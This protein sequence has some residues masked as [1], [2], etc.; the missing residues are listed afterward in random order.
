MS[1]RIRIAISGGGVAGAV[2]MHALLKHPHLNPHIFESAPQFKEAGIAFGVTRQAQAALALIG[3]SATEYLER[4]GGV[5]MKGVHAYVGQGPDAGELVYEQDNIAIGKKTTTIVQ[6]ANFLR[7]FLADVPPDRMHTSKKLQSIDRRADGSLLIHF[8]DGST[9]ECDVLIGCDGIH[10]TVRKILLGDDDPA[11]LPRNSGCWAVFTMHPYEKARA[12]IGNLN[13]NLEDA[14]EYGWIGEGGFMMTNL[15]SNGEQVQFTITGMDRD[16]A[17]S[18]KWQRTVTQQDLKELYVGKGWLPQMERAVND[19]L[20]DQPEHR[21]IYLWDHP[22]ARTYTDGPV[23]VLGDA[24]HAT[25]PFQASG[26]GMSIEDAMVIAALLGKATSPAEAAVALEVYDQV[27]RPRTQK[28]VDSSW[29][30]GQTMMGIDKDA[31][32]DAVKLRA[33]LEDRWD[34]IMDLDLEQHREEAIQLMDA[35]LKQ[36]T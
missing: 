9:H 1:Q 10:S 20:C 30:T 22:H 8:A 27:R 4:A 14:R 6:R 28:I 33:A 11:T 34:F 3:D 12:S 24:A 13:V 16:A 5:A 32:T 25:T 17:G 36:R 29:K 23:C 31:G 21:A 15:F 7:A 19:L 35:E 26:G 2:V 18:D